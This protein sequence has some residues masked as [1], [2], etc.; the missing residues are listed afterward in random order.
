MNK[1]TCECELLK[2]VGLK[3][4]PTQVLPLFLELFPVSY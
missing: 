3:D 1:V 2:G 4:Y